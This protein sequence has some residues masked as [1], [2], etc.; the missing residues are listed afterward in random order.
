[1]M[2]SFPKPARNNPHR[3]LV[4]QQ[5]EH[6]RLSVRRSERHSGPRIGSTRDARI[7]AL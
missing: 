1:V 3:V 5:D 6:V 4:T 2:R 7:R